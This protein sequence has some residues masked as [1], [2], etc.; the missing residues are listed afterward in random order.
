MTD[1][2]A[3]MACDPGGHSAIARGIF[4]L[5]RDMVAKCIADAR[6]KNALESFQLDMED[7]NAGVDAEK[8]IAKKIAM[9]W[10]DWDAECRLEGVAVDRSVFVMEDFVPRAKALT[11][12][13]EILIPVRIAAYVEGML[14]KELPGAGGRGIEYQQPG[15]VKGYAND[16]RLRKWGLWVKGSDH[17]RDA[18][19]HV[20]ARLNRALRGG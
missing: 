3:I 13:R 16:A 12:Q 18:W 7:S 5:D 9:E 6:R 17:Q 4:D 1:W 14:V 19:R 15:L 11:M 8:D 2:F 10:H 20:V